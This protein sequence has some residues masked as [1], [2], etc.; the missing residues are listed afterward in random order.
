MK[1]RIFKEIDEIKAEIIQLGRDI[2]DNPELGFEEY[3]TVGFIKAMFEKHGFTIEEKSGAL[4]TAFKAR[5]K[6]KKKGVTVAFLA[7]FDALPGLGHACGHNLIAAISTGAAIGLSRVMA[8][9]DGEIV[10]MGTPAE[11]GGGGKI[12]LLEKGEFDDLDYALMTHPST[13]NTIDKGCL[14]AT[15]MEIT[16]TG[17]SAHASTPEKG[18]NALRAVIQTFNLI[19]SSR[20]RMPLKSQISGIISNGGVA[21][22]V[23]PDLAQ[24]KFSVRSATFAELKTVVDMVKTVVKSVECFTGATATITTGIVYAER[25]QNHAIGELYKKYMEQQGEIVDY[26]RPDAKLGS[27]DIGNVSLKIPTVQTHV[28]IADE[29]ATLHTKEFAVAS[30]SDRAQ[31]GVMKAAKALACAGYEILTDENLRRIIKKE[32]DEKVPLYSSLSL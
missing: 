15:K 27:S 28:K 29:P 7:E 6:G 13:A 1:D 20:D 19:D 9:L 26:P 23:I 3:K 18:V 2:H 24:C 31:E 30:A 32:F 22:G 21:A 14:A 16:Y 5:L 4:D 11:E 25:Y 12:R 17:R 8:D 10:L